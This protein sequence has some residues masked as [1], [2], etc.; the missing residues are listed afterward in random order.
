MIGN[1]RGMIIGLVLLGLIVVLLFFG[2]AQRVFKS[3]GISYWL[4]FI[5][6]GALIGS[7]FIPTFYSNG[8]SVCVAGFI[9]PVIAATAF[10]VLAYR[11]GDIWRAV[12]AFAA[13]L[14][15]YVAVWVV[16]PQ[17]VG[18]TA[19]AVISGG[20]CGI[21]AFATSKTRASVLSATFGGMAV[22][23]VLASVVS[24]YAYGGMPRVGA[25]ATF[26]AI[27]LASVLAVAAFEATAA[28]RRAIV[29]RNRAAACEAAEEFDPDEYK[30]YFDE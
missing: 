26:D 17:L 19:T 9:A 13:T 3:F 1:N 4:A 15:A 2:I 12:V 18:E 10:F 16:L 7:A 5:V 22:G 21:V 27:I 25:A 29:I 23:D 30:K 11:S 24:A 8:V 20:L 28:I 14:A 6:V